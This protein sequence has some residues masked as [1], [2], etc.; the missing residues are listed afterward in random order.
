MTDKVDPRGLTPAV[1]ETP[2]VM[3]TL[4]W[5]DYA[6]IDSGNGRKLERYGRYT[7]VRPEPQCLWT[8]ALQGQA[9]RSLAARL[10]GGP[11]P[12]PLHRLPPPGLLSR[13]GR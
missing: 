5:D 1:A 6:L 7:V 13:T 9:H 11:V 3:R 12:R 10:G 8:L 2:G 4:P